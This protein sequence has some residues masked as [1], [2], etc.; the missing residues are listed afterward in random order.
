MGKM[1]SL[2]KGKDKKDRAFE[3]DLLRGIALIMMMF[4]HFSW[5]V[6]YEFGFDI[7]SYLSSYWFWVIV[8]PIILVLFVGVSGI[9]CS[10]SRNNFKRGLKLLAVAMAF[11]VVTTIIT[12]TMHIYCL[13]LFNVLHVL[14]ISMLIYALIS[15]IAN[16]TKIGDKALTLIIGMIGIYIIVLKGNLFYYDGVS[17]NPLLLMIGVELKD[18][19]TMADYMPLIPWMGVFLTGAALGRLIYPEKKTVF[20]EA[21]AGFRAAISPIEFLG[22]HSLI[23]YLTHQ[24]VMYLILYI[25]FKIAGKV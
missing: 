1:I 16:K 13:I 11:T 19:I 5:D 17:N 8:H 10:F 22:R 15:F 14:S 12:Y 7:F 18:G 21:T 3:L 9:C 6:R 25:I 24:P 20:P 2:F 23:I 4:M